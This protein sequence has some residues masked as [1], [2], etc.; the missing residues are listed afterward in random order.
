[1][2]VV[3]KADVML[4]VTVTRTPVEEGLFDVVTM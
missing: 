3:G 1:M 4:R 2:R